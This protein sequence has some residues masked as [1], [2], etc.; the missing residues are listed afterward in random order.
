MLPLGNGI[1]CSR[2][3]MADYQVMVQGRD[4]HGM[5]EGED[6]KYDKV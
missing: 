2:L 1:L 3:T 4:H 6:R 5:G